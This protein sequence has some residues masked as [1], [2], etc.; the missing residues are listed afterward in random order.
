MA[1]KENVGAESRS[2][3]SF[4]WNRSRC[5]GG[6]MPRSTKESTWPSFMAAP[7]MPPRTVTICSAASSWR[8]SRAAA[9]ASSLRATLA[10]RVP[11][12]FAA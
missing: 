10:A 5:S 8:R 6:T 12:R 1:S 7:F 4:A 3:A 9:A 2:F 11:A